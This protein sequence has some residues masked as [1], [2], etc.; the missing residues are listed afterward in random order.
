MR[1]PRTAAAALVLQLLAGGTPH[2]GAEGGAYK[3]VVNKGNPVASLPR[4]QVSALFLK[5]SGS[6]P[7]GAHALPVDQFG[8]LAIR[9]AFSRDVHGRSAAAIKSY[10]QQVIFSGRGLPPPEKDSDREVLSYVQANPGAIGYVS[11]AA[12]TDAVKVLVVEP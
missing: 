10:W 9:D 3:L 7:A 1:L 11:A 12:P 6:W 8:G 2:A 5:K 4:K